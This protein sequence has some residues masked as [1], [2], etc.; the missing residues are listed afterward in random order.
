LRRLLLAE[1]P[2][3]LSLVVVARRVNLT[4]RRA[5]RYSHEVVSLWY[6]APDILLGSTKYSTSVDIWSIGCI[7][8]EMVTGVAPFAVSESDSDSEADQLNCIM[9]VLGTPDETSF[10]R[11]T[12]LPKYE[13]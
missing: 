9:R 10:P 1:S 12:E 5:A 6:R 4:A 13:V 11:W 8:A 7:F 2:S 3:L